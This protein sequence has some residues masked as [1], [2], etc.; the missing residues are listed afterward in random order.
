MGQDASRAPPALSVNKEMKYKQ[1]P[2]CGDK[3]LAIVPKEACDEC[4]V[5]YVPVEKKAK[6]ARGKKKKA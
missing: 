3:I 2:I 5:A 4:D 1:C 6:K